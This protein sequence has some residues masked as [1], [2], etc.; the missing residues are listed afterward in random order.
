MNG[1]LD[2]LSALPTEAL[3]VSLGLIAALENLFPPVPA[4]SVVAFG[5]FLAARGRG[6]LAGAL[7]STWVGNVA[8]AML[9][10][11]LGRRFGAERL[12]R[13]LA[14]RN[15]EAIEARLHALYGRYG[16]GALFVS[17][18]LPGVRALVPP[19]AGALRIPAWHAAMMMGAASAIWYGVI[20]YAGFKAGT[21]WQRLSAL[22]TRYASAI[23]LGAA[24]V[25][26]IALVVWWVVR[27]R[28]RSAA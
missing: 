11:F 18:F 4:D 1:F 27:R 2:W 19:F 26:V 5:S 14:G 28:R 10:Y 22:V 16:L 23:G 21:D 17:R 25:V 3:Y 12:E 6:T 13:R 20:A 7:V 15:A 8:G 24:A 9:M